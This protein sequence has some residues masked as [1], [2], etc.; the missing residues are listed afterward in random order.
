MTV[1]DGLWPS[2]SNITYEVQIVQV[3]QNSPLGKLTS[4]CSITTHVPPIN[5]IFFFSIYTSY[6]QGQFC[7]IKKLQNHSCGS[8]NQA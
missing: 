6:K 3:E 8:H 2:I 1:K 7:K 4:H 5:Q